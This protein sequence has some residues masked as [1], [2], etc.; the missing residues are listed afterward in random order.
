MNIRLTS[1]RKAILD[2]LS[3]TQFHLTASQIHEALKERLPSLNLSTVY[4]SLD[5]LVGNR[6]VSV[7]DI[8]QGSPVYEIVGEIKHHHLV[9]LNCGHTIQIEN[10]VVASFFKELNNEFG[11]EILTNHLVLYGNCPG[12]QD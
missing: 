2:H 3:E 7:A 8:G 1:A 5:Y 9:C 10:D 6:L 4:R 12:C 11:F